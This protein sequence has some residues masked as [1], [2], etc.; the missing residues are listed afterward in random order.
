MWFIVIVGGILRLYRL[1]FQ[2]LWLDEGLQYYVAINN[3]IGDAFRPIRSFHPPLSFLINHAFF[4]IGDSEFFLRLPSALF[5]IASLPVL[6]ILT[7]ELTSRR[8]ALFSTI[9]LAIS[10]FHIWYSQEGRMYSQM[11]FL[12]LFSSVLL[13][14]AMKRGGARWWV[15]YVLVSAAGMFTHVFMALA[16]LTQFLWVLLYHR[17]RLIAHMASGAVVF[18]LFLPWMLLLPWIHRFLDR[19]SEHGL[20]GGAPVGSQAAFRAGFLWESIPYT[21]FAYSSGFSI[22][23]TVAELHENRSLAFI[24]Q[25]APEICLVAVVF[26]ALLLVGFCALYK[27]F[28]VRPAIFCL[29]GLSLPIFGALLYALAPRATYNVRY[30]VVGFPYFCIFLGAGLAYMF[31]KY[32]PAGVALSLSILAISSMSLANHFF[33]PR[34]AKEDIRAAVAFWRSDSKIEPLLSYRSRQVL[35]AYLRES[36][37]QR[38]S[39][40][41]DD[42]V[43]EINLFF[44]KTEAP[45]IY[46]LLA[47]DWR[48]LKEMA[49]RS[50]YR[51]ENEQ[52]YPGVKILRVVRG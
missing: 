42:V 17:D 18:V 33:N 48:Q 34:Y 10:P 46:I 19:V 45:S 26:G 25:F 31:Q 43:S 32:R 24:L 7:T 29:L 11:L 40:I 44:S 35:S 20:G 23:P 8:V 41:F 15:Y 49:I 39:P 16:L 14:Y 4:Q 50:A 2:S 13:L 28:G 36:E 21:F 27:L 51:I 1:D 9:V 37:K 6:Y 12:S 30:T 38:H 5:G 22:G 47:R 3:S 52:S